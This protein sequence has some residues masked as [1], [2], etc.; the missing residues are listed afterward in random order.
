MTLSVR[1]DIEYIQ[2]N[3][4][5]RQHIVRCPRGRHSRTLCGRNAWNGWIGGGTFRESLPNLCPRCMAVLRQPRLE[6]VE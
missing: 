4:D 3:H 6:G 1:L 5:D 2:F